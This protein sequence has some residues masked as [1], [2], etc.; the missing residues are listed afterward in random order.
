VKDFFELSRNIKLR[1]IMTFIG[2]LTFSTIGSSM[3][4]YYNQHMGASL[5]GLLL[6]ISSVLSF[7]VGIWS[8]HFTDI[9]GRKPTMMIG[10]LTSTFGAA[11]ATFANS[12]V[13]FNPWLTFVGLVAS[14]FGWGFFNSGASAML[15]DI[16][17]T[18][19]RKV[20]FSLNY[21]VLNIGVA[22][23]SGISGWLFR[24]HLFMLLSIVVTGDVINLLIVKFL[25]VETFDP[26][27]HAEHQQ[28]NIFKAYLQV[29]KDR[30]F[31]LYLL[32]T[33]FITMLFTQPDYFLPVHLS[34]NAFHT[35]H[36]FGVE[37]YGQRMLT[38]MAVTNTICV[39][40]FMS[41]FRKQTNK[42]S[43]RRG[44]AIGA[45]LMGLG[46]AMAV[47]SNNVLF[48]FLAA[49]L[50][51]G[52][53]LIFV[54][55]EQSLRADMM[56]PEQIGTYTGAFSA[57]QPMAQ[58]ICGALVSFSPLYGSMGMGIILLV[59]TSLGVLPGLVSIRRYERGAR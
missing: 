48:E 25:I 56:N 41:F 45:I 11:L 3:T 33:L 51:V 21:W 52:G 15:V 49:V 35:S 8:G 2:V 20:V 34:G 5:T 46:W 55:F 13:L 54:P 24:D 31:M 23:G 42:W 43:N 1:I 53:E 39:V 4:I 28:T 9:H 32:A 7:L 36:I 44:F 18:K 10:A 12:P 59:V 27:H 38:I 40:L 37:I 30:T 16:T 58:V 14:S 19:T 17:T 29:S 50:N 22:L 57:I 6:I 47:W 26:A